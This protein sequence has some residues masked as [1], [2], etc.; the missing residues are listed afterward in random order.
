MVRRQ[1][2]PIILCDAQPTMSRSSE[3]SLAGSKKMPFEQMPGDFSPEKIL[4]LS[5]GPVVFD[6]SSKIQ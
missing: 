4:F 5:H 1:Q 2:M 6:I 3:S